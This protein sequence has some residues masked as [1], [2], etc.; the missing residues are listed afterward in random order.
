MFVGF[1]SQKRTEKFT[2]EKNQQILKT[3]RKDYLHWKLS[4]K[5]LCLYRFDRLYSQDGLLIYIMVKAN[6][7]ISR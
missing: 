2:F 1:V 4:G 5:H 7:V 3:F 6:F